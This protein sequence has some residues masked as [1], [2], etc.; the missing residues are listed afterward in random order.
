[1]GGNDKRV[2]NL[3]LKEREEGTSTENK[4][5]AWHIPEK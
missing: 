2:S 5:A 4:K 3:E 1:M